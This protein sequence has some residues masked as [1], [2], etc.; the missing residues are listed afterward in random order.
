MKPPSSGRP[1]SRR[2]RATTGRPESRCTSTSQGASST[3]SSATAI[4]SSPGT[5]PR[6]VATLSA[7]TCDT[8]YGAASRWNSSPS[9]PS[10]AN[11][12]S[13]TVTAPDGSSTAA[14]SCTGG[15]PS[16]TA[17]SC[18]NRDFTSSSLWDS[19]CAFSS[20][21]RS[22]SR[23]A[24]RSCSSWPWAAAASR[25]CEAR[26]SSTAAF[27]ASSSAC[28]PSSQ[29]AQ[30]RRRSSSSPRS[31]ASCAS[32]SCSLA[33]AWCSRASACS[34]AWA[35][36][37]RHRSEAR[38]SRSLAAARDDLAASWSCAELASRSS[39]SRPRDSQLA[40]AASSSASRRSSLSSRSLRSSVRRRTRDSAGPAAS[41]ASARPSRLRWSSTSGRSTPPLPSPGDARGSRAARCTSPPV[42]PSALVRSTSRVAGAPCRSFG[43]RGCS[44][45]SAGSASPPPS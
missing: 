16:P 5:M 18:R 21:P 7:C 42:E 22:L 33:R 44:P 13:K 14:G 9:A 37:A 31:C 43:P 41:D 28:R 10:N 39:A 1:G 3:D 15:H 20:S 36:S 24:K 40:R 11:M 32:S 23:S 19:V 2:N 27:A 8:M 17:A 35:S 30:A 12:T 26:A 34:R 6:P 4:S 38:R 25:C 45:A 29:A